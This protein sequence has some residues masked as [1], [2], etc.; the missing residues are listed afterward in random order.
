M[1]LIGLC[2]QDFGLSFVDSSLS[3]RLPIGLQMIFVVF[4]YIGVLSLPESPRWLLSTGYEAEGERVVAALANSPIDSEETQLDKR[5]IL[6]SVR[7]MSSGD[8]K[9]SDVLTSGPTQHLRRTLLGCSSQFF[10]QI[11][12]CN[13]VIYF[14]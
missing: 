4:L 7:S 14:A 12:G 10:Q 3:W 13:A 9:P 8:L 11:G 5:V 1:F 6:E 2:D